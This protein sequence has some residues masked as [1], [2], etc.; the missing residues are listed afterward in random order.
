MR[1]RGAWRAAERQKTGLTCVALGTLPAMAIAGARRRAADVHRTFRDRAAS[2][3]LVAMI[4]TMPS[5]CVAL[6]AAPLGVLADRWGR[7]PVL[8][9]VAGGV[10]RIRHL[11]ML[12]H[13]LPAIVASRAIVGL[14]EA[15]IL[16]GQ[17]CADGDYF[18]KSAGATGSACRCRSVPSS[19]PA[20]SC[21]AA[22]SR[23]G[24]GADR[25]RVW[26]GACAA[27]GVVLDFRATA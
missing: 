26:L 6:C 27:R 24:R 19:V 17:Q 14:G 22:H 15:G 9:L 8:L 5:L 16:H 4:L 10:H 23:H 13:S 3:L 20:T 7:R 12:F 18:A 2:R 21:S 25:S 11:P 1:R